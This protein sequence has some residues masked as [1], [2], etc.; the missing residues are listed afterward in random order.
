MGGGIR[1][2]LPG[3]RA[4]ARRRRISGKHRVVGDPRV[5]VR[6]HHP[7]A[8]NAR[9]PSSTS[10]PARPAAANARGDASSAWAT[11]GSR[12]ELYSSRTPIERDGLPAAR[13]QRS[14]GCA[15]IGDSS[16]VK[17]GVRGPSER[18]N[19]FKS[20]QIVRPVSARRW[21]WYGP[22]PQDLAQRMAQRRD[23]PATPRD[24]KSRPRRS[25]SQPPDS[26]R[27]LGESSPE[28]S[29]PEGGVSSTAATTP[30][31]T[32]ERGGRCL[33]CQIRSRPCR[34]RSPTPPSSRPGLPP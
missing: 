30:A 5:C 11:R 34:A 27:R 16:R 9:C 32:H 3:L 13:A 26:G 25:R 20:R 24:G 1:L 22:I 4:S 19:T 33:E 31:F 12:T 17:H 14:G 6:V 8:A 28:D 10:R 7:E 29:R 18:R 21:A 2:R 23:P 15:A